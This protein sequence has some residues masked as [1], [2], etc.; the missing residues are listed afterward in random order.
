MG[1]DK[2]N[3]EGYYDPTTYEALTNIH[4]EEMAADKKA[5]YLPHGGCVQSIS[6]DVETNVMNAKRYSRFAAQ[7][8]A[9][10]VTPYL[11]YPQ[12]MDDSNEAEREMAMHF[13][14]VLLGKCTEVWVFGGVISRGMAREIGVAKKRRM[15]IRWFTQDLKEVGEYD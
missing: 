8:N 3:H 15:K 6:G 1:V 2:F 9:I 4:R 10:P 5:A 12:F 11:L 14:Y 7:K 13:N